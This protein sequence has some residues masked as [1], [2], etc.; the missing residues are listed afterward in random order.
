MKI[1]INRMI[2]TELQAED[3]RIE[4]SLRPQRLSEYIGQEKIRTSL[5]IY[6]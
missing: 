5:K 3:I 1:M 4:G 6:I 2:E